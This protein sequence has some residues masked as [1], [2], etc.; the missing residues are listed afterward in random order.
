[1]KFL[2]DENVPQSLLRLL[3]NEGH[4][5]LDVKKSE[6]HQKADSALVEL[7]TKEDRVILTYDQ[8]FLDTSLSQPSAPKIVVLLRY[9]DLEKV[10]QRLAAAL[11]NYAIE[12]SITIITPAFDEVQEL[13]NER[14][15]D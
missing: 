10:K 14:S 4:D 8:D 1:M 5:V 7:A 13:P 12:D 6:H 3:Q 9:P 15:W 2:V 11:E